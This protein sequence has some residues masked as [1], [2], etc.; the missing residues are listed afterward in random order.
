MGYYN[1]IFSR[2]NR[3]K[4]EIYNNIRENAPIELN[5]DVF[6]KFCEKAF[7]NAFF[8]SVREDSEP[9]MDNIL[10]AEIN[11]TPELQ[12]LAAR[13]IRNMTPE[14]KQKIDNLVG[15]IIER[16][17]KQKDMKFWNFYDGELLCACFYYLAEMADDS[18][19]NLLSVKQMLDYIELIKT[20]E[21]DIFDIMFCALEEDNPNSLAVEK[22]KI[23]KA[24]PEHCLDSVVLSVKERIGLYCGF[25]NMLKMW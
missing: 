18:L 1:E 25:E 15:Y 10:R 2:M 9:E 7:I 20:D 14:E 3:D 11:L 6:F 5:N 17:N 16:T 24:M 8:W 19:Q 4:Q 22:Y 21:K 23:F 12:L 13:A